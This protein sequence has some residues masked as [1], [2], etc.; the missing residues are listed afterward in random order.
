MMTELL[1]PAG[2]ID[3]LRAAVENGADA[4]YLG[5]RLFNARQYASNF[6]DMQ[7]QQAIDYAHL[8]DVKIYLTLNTLLKEAELSAALEY[9]NKAYSMGVDAVITQDLGFASLLRQQ[10]PEIPLHAST[11]MTTYNTEG[12]KLLA[13]MGFSRVVL[14]REV[15]LKEM[16]QIR[17]NVPVELEVFV[18]GAL[19]VSYSGQCLM[20]SMIGGRSGNRGTCAQPC[21][22]RYR[23]LSPERDTLDQG[24]LLSTRDICTVDF[25]KELVDRGIHSLKLEGRM[26]SPEYVGIITSKY[27]KALDYCQHLPQSQPLTQQDRKELLQIFNRGGFSKGYFY[28]KNMQQTVYKELPKNMGTPLGTLLSCHPKYPSMKVRLS[29]TIRLGD[30]VELLTNAEKRP[31]GIVTGIMVGGS[32]VKEAHAGQVVELSR[33]PVEN[34]SKLKNGLQLVKTSDKRLNEQIA[35]TY[36]AAKALRTIDVDLKFVF[37]ENTPMRLTL[38]HGKA[39]VQVTGPLPERAQT[40]GFTKE[41]L[42]AQLSKMDTYPFAVAKA[43]FSFEEGLYA[44]VSQLNQL[45][46]KALEALAD[47]LIVQSKKPKKSLPPLPT[48]SVSKMPAKQPPITVSLLCHTT[49]SFRRFLQGLDT[50]DS[51]W[52][53]V[54]TLL[55]PPECFRPT[56]YPVLEALRHNGIACIL[57]VP[58]VTK[59]EELQAFPMMCP[60]VDG[61]L[62]GTLGAFSL[63]QP[64]GKPVWG[65]IGLNLY[66]AY[67]GET[68]QQ[69]GFSRLTLSPEQARDISDAPWIANTEVIVYG[70]IPVMTSEH[71]PIGAHYGQHPCQGHR[72]LHY[73]QDAQGDT[74][75]ILCQGRGCRPDILSAKPLSFSA[76]EIRQLKQKGYRHFRLQIL[77][78][79]LE[80]LEDVL[81]LTK[82]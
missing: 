46:R 70:K 15:S 34:P 48:V 77:E 30:G 2:S 17:K 82:K 55:L 28:E 79:S 42:L 27:R 23:L 8:R 68:L 75:P 9:A 66:H 24:Y 47:K 20:S 22:Q 57:T 54:N 62:V 43:C 61:F 39:T 69:L 4:V 19:C 6:D 21:R 53:Q 73:L 14:S 36:T 38:S 78:E 31:G 80:E 33:I 37:Q 7:L 25:I 74:Y 12:T 5:G 63:V 72:K 67:T 71:C 16:G 64:Y 32:F 52:R 44:P 3:A 11:Q 41:R 29:D 58:T 60:Y 10:L 65:N 49:R 81:W 26:K 35:A 50:P 51:P 45:R 13:D 40:A 18:H 1:S 59:K 56:Y 76:E